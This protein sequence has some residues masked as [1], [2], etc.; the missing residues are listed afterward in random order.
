MKGIELKK[1]LRRTGRTLKEIS[2]LVGISPQSL[3][4]LLGVQ[5]VKSGVLEQLAAALGMSIAELYDLP[6][7]GVTTTT[8]GNGNTI[9][10][11]NGNTNISP[12]DCSAL[13]AEKD[14]QI[15]RLIDIVDKFT[16]A[17]K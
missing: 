16:D 7:G 17:T 3:N 12:T 2:E 6:T 1:R 13:L 14:E 4:Q 9:L 10:N 15:R 8:T 5:D 11:G